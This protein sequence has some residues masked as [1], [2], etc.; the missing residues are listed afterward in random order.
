ML[1]LQCLES[2][3]ICALHSG[4]WGAAADASRDGVIATEDTFNDKSADRVVGSNTRKG[5][6]LP[7]Q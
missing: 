5:E 3:C 1:R 4:E 6:L 7:M 2:L